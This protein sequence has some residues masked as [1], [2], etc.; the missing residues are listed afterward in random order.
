MAES[1][2]K[3]SRTVGRYPNPRRGRKCLRFPRA[4]QERAC[5]FDVPRRRSRAAGA[6]ANWT[7]DG[8]AHCGGCHRTFSGVTTFDQHRSQTGERGTCLDPETVVGKAGDRLLF[9]RGGIW[10]GPEMSDE[11]KARFG[12]DAA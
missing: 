8:R 4:R 6:A 5:G 11:A 2:C 9:D 7:G 10:S 1:R 12:R 3:R